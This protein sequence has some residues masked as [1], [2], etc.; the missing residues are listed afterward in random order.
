M[1]RAMMIALCL[2]TSA[3]AAK[4]HTQSCMERADEAYRR[5]TH[6]LGGISA[7]ADQPGEPPRYSAESAQSCESAHRD[8]L[9]QC[10][11]GAPLPVVDLTPDAGPTD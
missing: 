1:L 8:S 11:E 9:S 7:T 3:C 4:T 6:P 2:A 5:C 10:P